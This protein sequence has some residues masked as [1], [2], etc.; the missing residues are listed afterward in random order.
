MSLQ[1]C[2]CFL[3]QNVHGFSVL[4]KFAAFSPVFI[5]LLGPMGLVVSSPLNGLGVMVGASPLAKVGASPAVTVFVYSSS[6]E[7]E[8]RSWSLVD[9]SRVVIMCLALRAL[10]PRVRLDRWCSA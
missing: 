10:R 9:E 2:L 8:R 5:V 4:K 1:A 7:E 3:P 6:L